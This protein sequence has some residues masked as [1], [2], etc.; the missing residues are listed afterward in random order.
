MDANKLFAAALQLGSEWK[1]NQSELSAK[2][3]ALKIWRGCSARA[4]VSL[5]GMS[6]TF[7]R[8]RH[9]G[10]AV[11]VPWASA[12]S[13]FTLMMEAVILRLSREMS[14]SAMA[15]MLKEQDARL[16]RV[17]G[18]SVEKAYRQED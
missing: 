7:P 2:E 8:T 17:L 11:E 18:H 9:G 15:E 3:D 14:V 13:G 12:G 1:V 10:E 5:S 16:W 6:K 4:S